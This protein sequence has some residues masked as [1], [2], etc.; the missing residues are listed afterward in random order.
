VSRSVPAR[1]GGRMSARGRT[2]AEA[3]LH[4]GV[5]DVGSAGLGATKRGRYEGGAIEAGGHEA[6]GIEA[7][8]H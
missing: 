8:G 5:K 6:G 3:R 4:R 7:G 1:A 2:S